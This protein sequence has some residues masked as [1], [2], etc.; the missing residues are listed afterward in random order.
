[1]AAPRCCRPDSKAKNAS[2]FRKRLTV[3]ERHSPTPT[4]C[5]T[6]SIGNR[7]RDHAWQ[8]L[9]HA[10][11]RS[12]SS[13][14]RVTR[15]TGNL[16][17]FRV[18]RFPTRSRGQQVHDR[19]A[20]MHKEVQLDRSLFRT[21]RSRYIRSLLPPEVAARGQP[22]SVFLQRAFPRS[23]NPETGQYSQS[24]ARRALT[25]LQLTIALKAAHDYDLGH[26]QV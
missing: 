3:H 5:Q 2:S 21:F 14:S 23:R 16:R 8:T 25:Q 6:R 15:Q 7:G 20:S 26:Q 12:K 1:M 17:C 22:A 11:S 18:T 13:S 9:Q 4:R 10:R 24:W 19:A